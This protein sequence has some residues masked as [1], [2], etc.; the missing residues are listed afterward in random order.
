MFGRSRSAVPRELA[1]Q[2]EAA[3]AVVDTAHAACAASVA[4]KAALDERRRDHETLAAALLAADAL[5]RRATALA[6]G[7]SYLEWSHW[8]HRL[9]GLDTIRQRHLLWVS[10]DPS[11]LPIGSVRAVDTGMS[12]PAIGD[13]MHGEAKEPGAAATYGVD[14]EAALAA[15][16]QPLVVGPGV[17][18]LAPYAGRHAA[19]SPE[20]PPRMTSPAAQGEP[21]LVLSS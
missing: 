11:V 21:D 19:R 9:S 4:A 20:Q 13:L 18:P 12:G 3:L 6:K 7:R 10:D 15:L 1:A 16:E 14:Y 2:V 5:L 8:R 17:P